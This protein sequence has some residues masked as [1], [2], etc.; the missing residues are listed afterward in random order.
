MRNLK[1]VLSLVMAMALIVGMM[2]VSASAVNTKDFTDQDEIKHTEAVE[3]MV[4]LNVIAGQPDG[5]FDP[6]GSLTRAQMAKIVTYI[7]NGGVEPVLGV[8]AVPTYK[9]IDGHW[10]EKYIEY[11]TSMGIIAGVGSG[12]FDP[13]GTLTGSQAAKMLLTAMGYNANVF[14]FVGNDWAIN[15]SRYAN[16]AGLYEE[17]GGM[18]PSTTI[19]RD[20]ACQLA[21]NA[22]Q[23]PLMVR[24]WQMN[25][26]TGQ[27][28]ETYNLA[29]DNEGK[30]TKTLLTDKFG[31]LTFVGT[32]TN[33]SDTNTGIKDGQIQISGKLT[34]DA[35]NVSDRT[36][37]FTADV[38]ISNIGEEYKVIFKD[39]TG[40]TDDRP[41]DKDTVYGVFKTGNTEVLTATKGDLGNQKS[42]DAKI[43]VS[44]TE[45]N[46]TNTVKVYTNYVNSYSTYSAIDGT[47]TANSSLTTA[48]K[49][50]SVD[51]IK[52]IFDEDG[53]IEAAYVTVYAAGRV[54]A[55][56]SSKVTISGVGSIEIAEND[57]YEGI[58]LDDVVVYTKFYSTDKDKAYFTVTKAETLEGK[59][60]GYKID[61]GKYQNVVVDGTTYKFDKPQTALTALSDDGY[62][63][64]TDN[65]VGTTVRLY[66]M[67]GMVVGVDEVSEGA[68][69]YAVI[70]DTNAG[71]ASATLGGSLNGLKVELLF[72]DGTEAVKTVHKDST[73]D[74][75]NTIR[76]TDLVVGTL[77]KY[78]LSGD[79]QVKISAVQT[80]G[81]N[82]VATAPWDADSKLL[83]YDN[84]G[85]DT[86]T[87]AASNAVAYVK[88]GSD[89]YAFNLRGLKDINETGVVSTAM[90]NSDGL[91]A[92]AYMELATRPSGGTA[93]TI[94]GIV[95]SYVG[96]RSID[97]TSYN[98]YTVATSADNSVTVN[99]PIGSTMS[100]GSLVY[101][102]ESSDAIYNGAAASG[103]D[104]VIL[105]LSMAN[106]VAV[107]SYDASAGLLSYYDGTSRASANQAF[108]GTGSV[109]AYT[110]EK[111]VKIVYVDAD[112][113]KGGEEIGVTQFDGNTGYANA[114]VLDIDNDNIIDAVYVETSGKV[115]L[116]G[117]AAFAG[118]SNV[119]ITVPSS[120]SKDTNAYTAAG[121]TTVEVGATFTVSVTCA[122]FNQVSSVA[123]TY[124]GTTQ[125]LTFTSAGTQAVSFTA[126]A[127]VTSVTLA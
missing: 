81:A 92:A 104:I 22:I 39:G 5:S 89:Y 62:T 96:V 3:T 15:V 75:T 95:S 120:L 30:P 65:E 38:D 44:G 126:A 10:A 52:F 101:F 58:A 94:Y 69:Q 122:T 61:S 111:D 121:S 97:N 90:K 49:V 115:N 64:L 114:V 88:V 110:L 107:K 82:T 84:N 118:V 54:T 72:A 108:T 28:T 68:S 78:T 41:D 29:V 55:V 60:E 31:A 105:N 123:V 23:A 80:K 8:K 9:D 86:T 113:K 66:M 83:T 51:T 33:N 79:D 18:D 42:S 17:L 35:E 46:T 63:A 34:T 27:V 14:G 6:T 71:E 91:V 26:T 24:G 112:G 16:E 119:S 70:T 98:Q 67:N 73:Y 100:T 11:C 56:T 4:A 109:L 87:V 124:N 19:T 57:I 25:Q 13:E 12:Y 93:N 59:L 102:D 53:K 76:K 116:L 45:Y 32:F 103:K 36:A 50:Q 127:G 99:L 125:T 37:T 47:S 77:V 2:V 20:D 117:D 21:F 1:R 106:A 48:L 85:T 40:G 43:V 74:G 7:M